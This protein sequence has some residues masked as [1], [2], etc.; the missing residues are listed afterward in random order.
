MPFEVWIAFVGAAFVILVVP[1]PT[2]LLVISHSLKQGS[3]NK[4]LLVTAVVMG[5]LACLLLSRFGLGA[6]QATSPQLMSFVTVVCGLYVMSLGVMLVCGGAPEKTLSATTD[7]VTRF[8]LCASAFLVTAFN[9]KTL[10]FFVALLPLF[11]DGRDA[12]VVQFC[13]LGATF[14]VLSTTVSTTYS[15]LA[16]WAGQVLS[17]Q[18]ARLRLNIVSGSIMSIIG[19]IALLPTW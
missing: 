4:G 14:L 7:S 5:H 8:R 2:M 6:L 16:T 18:T 12:T 1:G 11:V 10:L 13:I 19:L 15:N 9:P 17:S 3:S